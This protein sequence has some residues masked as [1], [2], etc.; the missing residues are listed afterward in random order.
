MKRRPIGRI[1]WILIL[2]LLVPTLALAADSGLIVRNGQLGAYL[3]GEGGLYITGRD[4]R[5]NSR[6][7]VEIL[8]LDEERVLYRAQ[9]KGQEN[10]AVSSVALDT[11]SETVMAEG[12]CA[13]TVYEDALYFVQSQ[14]RTRLMCLNFATGEIT[15][16]AS[17]TEHMESLA[18]AQ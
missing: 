5:V 12:V 11:F 4:E 10:G 9:E 13:A 2:A 6:Y 16:A 18:H 3:D 15:V 7:A 17:T 8:A 1:A 14:D